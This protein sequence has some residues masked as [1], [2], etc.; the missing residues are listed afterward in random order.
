M[1]ALNK[2]DFK[3]MI[4]NRY[5]SSKINY[6]NVIEANDSAKTLTFM[7]GGAWTGQY[8]LSVRHN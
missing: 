2:K 6:L 4:I 7:Y 1:Y 5:N 3:A 8:N